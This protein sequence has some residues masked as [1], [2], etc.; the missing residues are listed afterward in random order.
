VTDRDQIIK[1]TREILS[2]LPP[3]VTLVAA[4]K[5]RTPEEV[6]AAIE[7]GVAVVGHNYVQ[8]ADRM[9]S[10]IGRRARWH[11]LGHLQKNK[12]KQAVEVFDLIESVDSVGLAETIDARCAAVHRTM[13]ILVEVNSGNEPNKTGVAPDDAVEL[14]RRL[15]RLAHVRVQGLMTMGPLSEE[16]EDFRPYFRTTR[17]LFERLAAAQLP[18]VEMRHLSMGMSSSFRVAIE[19]GANMVRIGTAIFGPRP[20]A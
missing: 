12:V 2:A 5:T 13:P 7:A 17:R 19:E 20:S 10:V 1:A 8:E 9:F 3:G 16:P 11:L 15:S 18:N 4:A 6:I 14:I